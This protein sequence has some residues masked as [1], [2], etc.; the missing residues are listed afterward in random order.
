MKRAGMPVERPAVLVLGGGLTGISAAMH[1]RRPWLLLEKEDRL[2]GHAR[3]DRHEGWTFDR[4]GHWLHLRDAYTQ[5]LFGRLLGDRLTRV[6]R[7][8]R[9]FANGVLTR[10]PF[11]ANLFGQ[12]PE[13]VK[14]CLLGFIEAWR[15]REA[16]PDAAPP[17]SFHDFILRSYGE[18]IARHFM[19]PYN[20]K[21]WG[22]HPREITSAWCSRFVPVPNL[23]ETVAGAVGAATAEMGYNV[24]FLYPREGGIETIVHALAEQLDRERGAVATGTAFDWLD[25]ARRVAGVGGEEVPYRAVVATVPLPELMKR[26]RGLPPALEAAAA[27]LRWTPVRYLNVA[28]RTPPPAAFHWIYAPEER[29]PFYRAGIFTNAAR[30]M[31][32]MFKGALYVEL[33]DRGPRPS[34]AALD[35]LVRDVAGGLQAAGAIAA[36]EDIL[37]ADPMELEYAYV[38]FDGHYDEATAAIRAWLE[39]HD[40][41]PRGRYG[42]WTYNAMEDCVLAGREVAERIERRLAPPTGAGVGA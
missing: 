41:Y 12:P 22:V 26:V 9:I 20:H 18:G 4:T 1:L 42:W 17:R 28:T 34:G 10:Y 11:Q 7:H 40:I 2:G 5:E 15:R 39:S 14:E 6:E 8:A 31:A 35:A 25:P 36:P 23:E 19:V 3:S 33:A 32:P 16:E 21:L 24:S 13:V 27:R 30:S 38:V 37:F 29:V